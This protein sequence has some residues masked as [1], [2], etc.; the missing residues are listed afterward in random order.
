LWCEENENQNN[1]LYYMTKELI[2]NEE[3]VKNWYENNIHWITY[4]K[5]GNTNQLLK[6]L[7]QFSQ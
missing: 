1:T 5:I 2:E 4:D 7:A 3:I 6:R